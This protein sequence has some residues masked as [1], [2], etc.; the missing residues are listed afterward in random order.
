ML[1]RQ[2]EPKLLVIS[3]KTLKLFFED[4]G[5]IFTCHPQLQPE[6]SV[7]G[8]VFKMMLGPIGCI[9]TELAVTLHT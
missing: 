5:K 7:E 4:S 9:H 3:M 8:S 2:K 6:T 1:R